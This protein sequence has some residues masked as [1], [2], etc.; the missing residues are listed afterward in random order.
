MIKLF[1]ILIDTVGNVRNEMNMY[2]N[3]HLLKRLADS[4]M[5]DMDIARCIRDMKGVYITAADIKSIMRTAKKMGYYDRRRYT[6]I[7]DG[8]LYY[9]SVV[10][11]TLMS[12]LNRNMVSIGRYSRVVDEAVKYC[13][14][15][16]LDIDSELFDHVYKKTTCIYVTRKQYNDIKQYL[17]RIM[18]NS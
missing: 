4:G 16:N 15:N 12:I 9:I 17:N 18:N 1:E 5:S 8:L 13:K 11:S 2:D 3:V 14:E 10:L 7:I 6:I